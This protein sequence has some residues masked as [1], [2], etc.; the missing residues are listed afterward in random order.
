MSK[1][2]RRHR[3]DER[4]SERDVGSGVP[5]DPGKL[6]ERP[7]PQSGRFGRFLALRPDLF[8]ELVR[9]DGPQKRPEAGWESGRC[10][11]AR[12]TAGSGIRT[13]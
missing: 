13:E 9:T 1:G 7:D 10:G 6:G 5:E 2:S 8:C 12:S 3:A 11:T 4:I